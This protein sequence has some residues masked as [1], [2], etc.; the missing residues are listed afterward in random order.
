M[1]DRPLDA[2]RSR[3]LVIQ[4]A[5]D[6][7]GF[8][9][10]ILDWIA[11]NLPQERRRFDLRELPFALPPDSDHAL[12]APWLQDPVEDRCETTYRQILALE[13][14]CDAR[15][16]P[17][18]N[19]P[20]RLANAI[21]DSGARRMA[22]AGLRTPRMLRIDD[23]AAFRRDFG[24]LDFPFFVRENRKH[25]RRMLR[26]DDPDQ[27]RAL[28]LEEFAAPVA[29]ELIDLADPRDGL[30]RK[31]R[32]VV[33]GEFGVPH[34]LQMSQEWITRGRHRRIDAQS[35]AEELRYIGTPCPHH[36]AFQRAR[37]A[38]ELDFVAFDYGL[39]A[40]GEAVVWE[41]N[42]YP[43]LQFS[44]TQLAYRNEAIHRTLAILVAHYY[45]RAGL[46]LPARLHDSL[47]ACAVVQPRPAA[48]AQASD[49]PPWQIPARRAADRW[50]RVRRL[51]SDLRNALWRWRAG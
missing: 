29:I 48:R 22:A 17:V 18:V 38:L 28:P 47:A 20:E 49:P 15:G 33:A 3:F 41:A 14:Q 2:A 8:Y 23:P 19:R 7:R 46:A 45:R 4:H 11:L 51:R 50:R 27:A 26:A 44:R 37:E 42:P 35:E 25:G 24:G 13:A 16:I 40:S 34:H 39:D 36:A 1:S 31:Y 21:K 30:Y 9:D 43:L 12:L 5:W 6:H 10:V 32:Y